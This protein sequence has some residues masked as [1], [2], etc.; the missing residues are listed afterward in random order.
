[1]IVTAVCARPRLFLRLYIEWLISNTSVVKNIEVHRN[2]NIRAHS[3]QIVFHVNIYELDIKRSSQ[4]SRSFFSQF[5]QD[6]L[7][8]HMVLFEERVA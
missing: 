8:L 1:M 2:T 5:Q 6:S 3:T 4:F 7:Q